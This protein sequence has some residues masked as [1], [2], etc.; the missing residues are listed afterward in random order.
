VENG[1]APGLTLGVDYTLTKKKWSYVHSGQGLGGYWPRWTNH[2]LFLSSSICAR[3]PIIMFVD[4]LGVGT[5]PLLPAPI[6]KNLQM[7]R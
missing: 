1:D 3:R 6:T 2:H 4:L 7:E 5:C